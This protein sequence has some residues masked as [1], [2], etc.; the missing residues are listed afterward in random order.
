[1]K[2]RPMPF[3]PSTSAGPPRSMP[4]VVSFAS[5]LVPSAFAG[6]VESG[7]FESSG[8]F[9]ITSRLSQR[10]DIESSAR[11][12]ACSVSTSDAI[13][14]LKTSSYCRS[15]AMRLDQRKR[16]VPSR[17]SAIA[18]GGR[19]FAGAALGAFLTFGMFT[20]IAP[21]P[22]TMP[23]RVRMSYSMCSPLTRNTFG[24]PCFSA[25]SQVRLSMRASPLAMK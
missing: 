23:S 8:R 20:R 11:K 13:E 14:I 17:P 21:L 24:S 6:I 10:I 19:T 3:T 7:V 15:I 9:T 18:P 22:T 12:P 5:S 1:M 2:T 16:V 25:L 4:R